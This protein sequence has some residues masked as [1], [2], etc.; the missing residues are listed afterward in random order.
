MFACHTFW[1]LTG[2]AK[3]KSFERWMVLQMKFI[4]FSEEGVHLTSLVVA[5]FW[6]ITHVLDSNCR[7]EDDINSEKAVISAKEQSLI[8]KI[9]VP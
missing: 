3:R 5:Q 1:D 4:D 6:L 7:E 2:S 9:I 8:N